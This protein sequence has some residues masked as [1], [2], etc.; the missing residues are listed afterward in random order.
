MGVNVSD[1]ESLIFGLLKY[2]LI[3]KQPIIANTVL[4][5]AFKNV[6]LDLIVKVQLGICNVYTLFYKPE[7]L[8][9]FQLAF[10]FHDGTFMTFWRSKPFLCE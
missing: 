2:R 8:F 1:I 10:I 7:L 6:Y 5:S 9:P 4:L 3:S